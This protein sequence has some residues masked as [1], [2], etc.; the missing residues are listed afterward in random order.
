MKVIGIDPSSKKVAATI[1]YDEQRLEMRTLEFSHD[2]V[3]ACTEAYNW[4]F[5]LGMELGDECFAAIEEPVVGRGGVYSTLRQT[6]VHGALVAG[7]VNSGVET[8]AINNKAW[9]KE[10]IGNGNVGKPL[11]KIWVKDYWPN[12]YVMAE[13]DQDLLD[14]AVINRY[15]SEIVERRKTIAKR[16]VRRF[17]RSK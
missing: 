16:I 13:D 17:V 10:I 15:A 12:A 5:D 1:T 7:L 2:I 4:A 11:I 9:K 3:L 6:K 8:I 14:S